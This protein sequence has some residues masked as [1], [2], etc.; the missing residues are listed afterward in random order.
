MSLSRRGFMDF[1]IPEVVQITPFIHPQKNKPQRRISIHTLCDVIQSRPTPSFEIF[2]PMAMPILD[3]L[4]ARYTGVKADDFL[5]KNFI[6]L[7]SLV[8]ISVMKELPSQR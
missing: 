2:L 4:R 3:G 8:G 6:Q 5:L 7:S 1:F